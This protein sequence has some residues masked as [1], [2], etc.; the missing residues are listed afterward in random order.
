MQIFNENNTWQVNS[1]SLTLGE[2]IM[3]LSAY[4]QVLIKTAVF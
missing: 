2:L 1:W 4:I 3:A